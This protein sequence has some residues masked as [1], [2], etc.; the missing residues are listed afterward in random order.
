[1][2]KVSV[3]IVGPQREFLRVHAAIPARKAQVSFNR[4]C[5][6]SCWHMRPCSNGPQTVHTKYRLVG[7]QERILP[8]STSQVN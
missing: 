1:M 7:S 2:T 3:I 5:C 4:T 8:A 6:V